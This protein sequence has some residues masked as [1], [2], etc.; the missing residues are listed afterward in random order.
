[1]GS[2]ARPQG[3]EEPAVSAWC[4]AHRSRCPVRP[5]PRSS[6]PSTHVPSAWRAGGPVSMVTRSHFPSPGCSRQ[7]S[8]GGCSRCPEPMG[9]GQRWAP[10]SRRG[11]TPTLPAL[12]GVSPAPVSHP[13]CPGA[14]PGM[15]A[16]PDPHPPPRGG[17]GCRGVPRPLPRCVWVG[18][19]R[20]H[21]EVGD[22]VPVSSSRAAGSTTGPV[23]RIIPVP[24]RIPQPPVPPA[25]RGT[26][27]GTATP[28]LHLTPRHRGSGAIGTNRR[29]FIPLFISGLPITVSHH[30]LFP[31]INFFLPTC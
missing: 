23:P 13:V 7:L 30:F 1:M 17:E 12:L 10:L 19:P 5:V 4:P 25:S 24:R 11:H 18:G 16:V 20:Q 26:G 27:L 29:L 2:V 9:D 6:G 28:C 14:V 22:P 15:A 31:A 21:G 3:A 8:G